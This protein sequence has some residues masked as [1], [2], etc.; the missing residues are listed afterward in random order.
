[1]DN[2]YA[3]DLI[4]VLKEIESDLQDLA[5]ISDSINALED[6]VDDM[7]NAINY[8]TDKLGDKENEN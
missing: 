8:L 7:V 3:A 1:M 4:G 6:S 5:S 2:F